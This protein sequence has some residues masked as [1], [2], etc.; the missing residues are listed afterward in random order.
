MVLVDKQIRDLAENNGLINNFNKDNLSS[1]SYDI[2]I[3][4]FILDDEEKE[5]KEYLIEPNHYIFVKTRESL[6]MPNHLCCKVIEKNSLMRKGLKVDGP[7]YQPGHQTNIYIR[8]SNISN[9]NIL[10]NKNDKIAQLIFLQLSEIPETTYDKQRDNHYNNEN[11][12][13]K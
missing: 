12:F 9:Q 11:Y 6:Q 2:T 1:I 8:V 13:T 4:K 10:L 3:D 5:C 7:L